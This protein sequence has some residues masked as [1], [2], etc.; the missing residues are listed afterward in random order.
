MRIKFHIRTED[1]EKEWKKSKNSNKKYV[2]DSKQNKNTFRTAD[3]TEHQKRKRKILTFRKIRDIMMSMM[4]I[5]VVVVVVNV[6]NI[7]VLKK[8]ALCVLIFV[9]WCFSH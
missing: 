9:F 6:V 2:Q 1:I 8:R 4:I 7:V 5:V 3:K